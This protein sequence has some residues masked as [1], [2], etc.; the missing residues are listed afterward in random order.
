MKWNVSQ[1]EL[2]PGELT[3]LY[4]RCYGKIVNQFY[5]LLA[6]HQPEQG[7]PAK[8]KA[9]RVKLNVY[10]ETE[11]LC[12]KLVNDYNKFMGGVDYNNQMTRLK[13][14]KRQKKGYTILVVKLFL[15]SVIIPILYINI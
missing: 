15:C 11:F 7:E 12:P 8:L 9:K 4:Y 6:I 14:Q 1:V 3:I 5:F 13:K 10:Q 2:L